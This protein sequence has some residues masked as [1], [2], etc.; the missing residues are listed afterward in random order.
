M[1]TMAT[2]FAMMFAVFFTVI[3]PDAEA[4]RFASG[5]SYGKSYRTEPYANNPSPAMNASKPAQPGAAAAASPARGLMGGLLGGLLAGGLIAALFGGA[6]SGL[7]I[8]DFLII[9]LVAFLIFRFLRARQQAARPAYAGP[10]GQSSYGASYGNA[11]NQANAQ[12]RGTHTNAGYGASSQGGSAHDHGHSGDASQCPFMSAGRESTDAGQASGAAPSAGQ[13]MGEGSVPFNF[14]PDF[15]INAF[16]E[17]ARE[18]YRTL[19]DAWNKNE[20][21]KIR[22]YVSPDIVA[23]LEAERAELGGE[24]HTEVLFV[25]AE[26]VRADV[27]GDTAELSIRFR[28]AYRDLAEGTGETDFIDIWHLE[29]DLATAG[30]PWMIVGIE[31]R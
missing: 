28:G 24:Q 20:F 7:Q 26:V 14:P 27:Q 12:Y 13:G 31:S 11:Q 5:K 18:H 9:G 25:D 19:Q 1:K 6:F 16:L 21:A 4:K 2:L 8:M 29:R 15:R 10:A 23:A 17:G 30:A 3:A 22:E